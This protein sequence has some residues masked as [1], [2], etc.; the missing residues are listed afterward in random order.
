[1]DAAV[2]ALPTRLSNDADGASGRSG[3]VSAGPVTP[4]IESRSRPWSARAA[5]IAARRGR[6]GDWSGCWSIRRSIQRGGL[7]QARPTCWRPTRFP[8]FQSGRGGQFTY[9]GPGQR[10]AYVMLDLRCSPAATPALSSPRSKPGSIERA[11]P[12][13]NRRRS[14]A[15]RGSG[16]GS[17]TV[18]SRTIAG[19]EDRRDRREASALDQLPRCQP[20][21]RDRTFRALR[22]ESSPAAYADAWRHQPGGFGFRPRH[23]IE[24]MV[25]TALRGSLRPGGVRSRSADALGA[26]LRR[27]G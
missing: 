27:R 18:W 2:S 7:G 25:D 1:M 17:S 3:A 24:P 20:E 16:Y 8:V 5:A 22:P 23:R 6:D 21:R 10:V 9:H 19:G 15:H 14:P 12:F 11:R 26:D 13:R 4:Y